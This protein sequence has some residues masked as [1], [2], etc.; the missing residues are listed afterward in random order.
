MD[1]SQGVHVLGYRADS[2]RVL[3]TEL[4]DLARYLLLLRHLP[5]V[6]LVDHLGWREVAR[7]PDPIQALAYKLRPGFTLH[8]RRRKDLPPG[9]YLAA[10][11]ST[12]QAYPGSA[13]LQTIA[14]PL[15]AQ[16]K[17]TVRRSG[18]RKD[19][20]DGDGSLQGLGSSSASSSSAA[21]GRN[22]QQPPTAAAAVGLVSIPPAAAASIQP[23]P[24]APVRCLQEMQEALQDDGDELSSL[25]SNLEGEAY[26]GSEATERGV[27][28]AAIHRQHSMQRGE[29]GSPEP[30]Q[31]EDD[32]WAAAR[33]PGLRTPV[34][35]TASPAHSSSGGRGTPRLRMP[36]P[37]AMLRRF[38]GSPLRAPVLRAPPAVLRRQDTLTPSLAPASVQVGGAGSRW[39][40]T[41]GPGVLTGLGVG[42]AAASPAPA[43]AARMLHGYG[44]DPGADK[45]VRM[46]LEPQD[47]PAAFAS[48]QPV[49][50][51]TAQE[52]GGLTQGAEAS[53]GEPSMWALP[54]MRGRLD[55]VH[56]SS[57][58]G[59]VS[60]EFEVSTPA[61]TSGDGD[62]Q[63]AGI[64]TAESSSLGGQH[65]QDIPQL[66]QEQGDGAQRPRQGFRVLLRRLMG[67]P[68]G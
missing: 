39:T 19:L 48:A 26:A 66:E 8:V 64:G 15:P 10:P 9:P 29:R 43:T 5:S 68:K 28:P 22:G 36:S 30:M 13:T 3:D 17:L 11:T 40:T 62:V 1:P 49:A 6:R 12:V 41:R 63:P 57:Q 59:M 61:A 24:S 50:A 44:S 2:D 45:D 27:S 56:D 51:P 31:E 16:L 37:D 52:G 54:G 38:Q 7:A 34:S 35:Y 4:A 55:T 42:P 67:R 23:E 47:G 46:V 18:H 32:T 21:S 58:E 60:P 25:L 20:S 65:Q 33:Q 14:D 53:S